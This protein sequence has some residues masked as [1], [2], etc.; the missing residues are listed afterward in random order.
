MSNFVKKN[1]VLDRVI[2]KAN[3]TSDLRTLQRLT[4]RWGRR[5]EKWCSGRRDCKMWD[6]TMA[7]NFAA[8][9]LELRLRGDDAC[10]IQQA[11]SSYYVKMFSRRVVS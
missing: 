3:E 10:W 1:T 6:A 11:R 9:A 8:N 2:E 5:S 4:R 7:L